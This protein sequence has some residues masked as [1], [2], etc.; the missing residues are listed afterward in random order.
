VKDVFLRDNAAV[1]NFYVNQVSVN[2]VYSC[3]QGFKKHGGNFAW[4]V[5]EDSEEWSV[6][7]EQ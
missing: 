1:I 4:S 7:S 3:T 6:I 5:A 2:S